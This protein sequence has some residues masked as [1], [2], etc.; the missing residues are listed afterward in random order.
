[1]NTELDVFS[2]LSERLKY[3]LPNFPL[4][5]RK[6]TLH[7][8]A[9]YAAAC[10]WHPDL[11]YISVLSGSMEYF[12]N[13]Q[14]VHIDEGN[15]IFV[16]SKRLH[17][18]FSAD[19]TD[20]SYIVIAVHPSLLGEETQPGKEYLQEKFGPHSEDYLLLSYQISWQREVLLLMKQL[21]DEMG[22]NPPNPLHL[23]S[24]ATSL[25][26]GIGD[27]ILP[28]FNNSCDNES[29]TT[30]WKMVGFIHQKY[31]VK[32]T[33]NEIAA[34]GMVCRSQCCKLFDKYIG[35]SPNS[36][37]NGY[38]IQKSCEML[39]ETNRSISEIGIAC[40]FQTPSYFS[41]LFHKEMGIVPNDYRKRHR[42]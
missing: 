39:R 42:E 15:G 9:C 10:H 32:I 37:L 30:F 19:Q 8:F 14:T 24:Q 12:I 22:N 4:Y 36:Y 3:N 23:L 16:N 27:H 13:G 40:G 18:G 25:C 5:V 6:G 35:L 33:L 38:R 34:A 41:Y 28:V 31:D 1:M 2:D 17:Y 26:A 7:Q 21:F 29:W 20:C 11:E